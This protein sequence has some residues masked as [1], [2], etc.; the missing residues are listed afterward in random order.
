MLKIFKEL[1]VKE[2]YLE[3]LF[4]HPV[5]E[6]A[7]QEDRIEKEKG[8]SPSR[9]APIQWTDSY[10][11]LK[12]STGF[13]RAAFL[14]GYKPAVIPTRIEIAIPISINFKGKTGGSSRALSRA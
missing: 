10:S 3:V 1:N 13:M 4:S 11:Y 2:F 14:A 12:A 5:P 6:W 9:T 8:F 7:C